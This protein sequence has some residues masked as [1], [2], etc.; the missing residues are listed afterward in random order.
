M[1]DAAP[2]RQVEFVRLDGHAVR[3]TSWRAG[4]D[5]GT[6]TMV[7]VIRGARDAEVLAGLLDNPVLR[8]QVGNEP[9][10]DV[11]VSE[12][13]RKVV[14]E[15]QSSISRFSAVLDSRDSGKRASA[16]QSEKTL[17]QRV[18]NLESE[19]ENLR[20]GLQALMNGRKQS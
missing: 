17:D 2:A 9:Q 8:L 18:A 5:P 14:G 19:V 12:V 10:I 3:V 16:N 15:G 20:I 4:N 13:E 1:N 11:T 6:W 7:A